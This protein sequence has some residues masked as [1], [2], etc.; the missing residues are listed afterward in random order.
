MRARERERE[1][2]T[3]QYEGVLF[4]ES[5]FNDKLHYLRLIISTPRSSGCKKKKNRRLFGHDTDT[6]TRVGDLSIVFFSELLK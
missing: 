1:G 4:T 5:W 6:Q 2:V 3:K